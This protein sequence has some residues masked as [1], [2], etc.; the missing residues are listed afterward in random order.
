M[1]FIIVLIMGFKLYID[2][3]IMICFVFSVFYNVFV[4]HTLSINLV[5]ITNFLPFKNSFKTFLLFICEQIYKY[6]FIICFSVVKCFKICF[7]FKF[8]QNI[9]IVCSIYL[10]TMFEIYS[11]IHIDIRTNINCIH[12]FKSGID[13]LYMTLY[14]FPV[15]FCKLVYNIYTVVSSRKCR[16]GSLHPKQPKINFYLYNSI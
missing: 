1:Y 11:V 16:Q 9:Y 7:F 5:L 14:F 13:L 2:Y 6:L 8:V 15:N 4:I 3:K 10:F 12:I